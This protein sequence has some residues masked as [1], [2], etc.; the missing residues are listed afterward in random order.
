MSTKHTVSMISLGCSKN[1]VDA[2]CMSTILKNDGYELVDD[3]SKA[4]AAVINTCGFI[5]SAK[6]EAIDTILDVARLKGPRKKL[7]YIVVSGCLSQRYPNEIKDTLPEVDAVLGTSHYQDISKVLGKLFDSEKFGWNDYIGKPGSLDHMQFERE[8][9]TKPYAW[10]KIAEGCSNGC[11]F[12]AIPGIRGKYTSRPMEDIL[13][14]AKILASKGYSEIILAAQDST[15][16]GKDLYG[17]RVLPEL[18]S[19]LSKIKGIDSIRIMYAYIDGIDDELIAEMKKNKK[20]LH[21]LDI[22][23][24][25]GDDEILKK[26]RRR[27]TVASITKTLNKLRTAIPDIVIRST[28]M[29]GFPGEKKEHFE[30]L[31]KNLKVW[32]F[33]CLGCFIYSP[34]E[35]TLGYKMHP[36]VRSDVSQRRYEK[37]ME[38]QQGISLS[39]NEARVGS[40]VDVTIDS[41]SD[42]GIFYIGRSYAEAPEVDPV[43]YVASTTRP[44][45]LG[46]KVSVKILE[47]TPYDMTG[48]TEDESTK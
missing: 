38:L 5:E 16:Y 40:T 6:K 37:V 31:L 29:V 8:V 23:V 1:M 36:R 4:E 32:R 44:L 11:A 46:D 48:V 47:C 9:S 27:D 2:E 24:Q 34:E 3:I 20:V 42:D 45:E 22:P 21:Y 25:H 13:K 33:Q 41:V 39:Y 43:I 28:V 19:K 30:N 17:K 35:N 7:K 10:L 18:L 14:E 26:M 12:C 15:S